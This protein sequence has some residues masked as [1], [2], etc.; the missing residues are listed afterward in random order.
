ML[1]GNLLDP[2]LDVRMLKVIFPPSGHL[3]VDKHSAV[4]YLGRPPPLL[5]VSILYLGEEKHSPK[6]G[7]SIVGPG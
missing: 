3:M 6:R 4:F 5:S 7:S 2:F 1:S